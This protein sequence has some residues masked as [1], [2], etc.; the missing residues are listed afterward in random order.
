MQDYSTE[1]QDIL[2]NSCDFVP[3]PRHTVL[4]GLDWTGLD[5]TEHEDEKQKYCK[6]Y[7]FGWP[8]ENSEFED[9]IQQN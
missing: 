2:I 8:R 9:S 5:W 6:N 3:R 7:M 4:R 1:V